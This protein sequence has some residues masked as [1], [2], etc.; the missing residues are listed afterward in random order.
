MKK[1]FTLFFAC[2][3]V[4]A[5]AQTWLLPDTSGGRY[6]NEIFSNVVTTSNISYGQAMNINNTNQVLQL[7]IYSPAGD[8]VSH[9]PLIVLAH[10]GSFISGSRTSPDVVTLCTRLAK[11]GYVAVSISYRLGIGFPIDSINATKAVVRATQDMKAAVRFFRQDAMGANLYKTHPNYVFAGGVSAGAF[12]GLHLAY[13]DQV[14]EVPTWINLSTIGGL[15]GNS[16]NPGYSHKVNAVINL[17]GALGDSSWLVSGD[18]PLLSMHGNQD[19]TVPFGTAMIY[20][21]SFPVMIVDGSASL[22]LRANN[23]GVPNTFYPWWGQDHVPFTSSTAYMDS[24][25]WAI[26]DFLCPLV[27]QPS[28]TGVS[29]LVMEPVLNVY[30]NPAGD[31]FTLSIPGKQTG[32]TVMIFDVNGKLLIEK[33][34]QTTLS[35]TFLENGIYII[36]VQTSE[37]MFYHTRLLKK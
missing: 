24:T 10:G 8:T 18:P 29:E 19:A 16:G 36:R 6:C 33:R 20:V 4:S 15:E 28:A 13:L 31:Q 37:G 21:L 22:E 35:C 1:I 2:S 30:P 17:C 27:V 3:T 25:V 32:F 23:V 14:S 34:D 7:D 9:K 12:M 11:M 26:R 5:F